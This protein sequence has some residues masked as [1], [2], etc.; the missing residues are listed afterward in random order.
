[1]PEI[2]ISRMRV[3]DAVVSIRFTRMPDGRSDYEVLEKEGSLHVI[4][5][6]S[7]WSLTASFG[8]RVKDLVQGLVH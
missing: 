3:A 5:Q 6:P 2:T 8:E 7:P 4:R 1:L